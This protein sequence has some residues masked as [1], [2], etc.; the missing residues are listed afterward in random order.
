MG[1]TSQRQAGFAPPFEIKHKDK[2]TGQER[3]FRL[4]MIDDQMLAAIERKLYQRAL[5]SIFPLKEG[6][7]PEE[8][9]R[10]LNEAEA[11][12]LAGEFHLMSE[13]AKDFFK[14]PA[15]LI[16]FMELLF[17]CPIL[18][19]AGM[20]TERQD[21]IRVLIHTVLKESIDMDLETDLLEAP[22]PKAVSP[23]GP[24]TPEEIVAAGGDPKV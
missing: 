17:D 24:L 19:M 22:P 3:T 8:Y 7:D 20:I 13:A 16:F 23:K 15:G 10:Q 9:S 12:Y 14:T 18:E 1:A 4:R 21:E 5:A 6:L 2:R 11:K